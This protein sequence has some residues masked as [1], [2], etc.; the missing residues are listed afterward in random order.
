ML[1]HIKGKNEDLKKCGNIDK[2][3]LIKDCFN[4]KK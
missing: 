3:T 1:V 2:E 4:D